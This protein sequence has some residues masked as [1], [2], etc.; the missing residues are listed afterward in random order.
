MEYTARGRNWIAFSGTAGQVRATFHTEIHRYRVDREMHFAN[1][2]APSIPAALAPVVGVIQD[3]DAPAP[4]GS[5]VSVYMTGEGQTS[6][7][8]VTGAIVPV[9]APAPG[10]S[11]G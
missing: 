6:P 10:N 3:L 8:G 11:R 5:V 4:K 7:A 1:A 2:T 9:H